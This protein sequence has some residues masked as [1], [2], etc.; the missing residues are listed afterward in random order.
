MLLS[1]QQRV[2]KSAKMSKRNSKN[3]PMIKRQFVSL[4]I[5]SES[6]L[7]RENKFPRNNWK[8]ILQFAGESN[9]KHSIS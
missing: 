5:F 3:I 4:K 6:K 2:Q 1:T 8:I 9:R 7:K